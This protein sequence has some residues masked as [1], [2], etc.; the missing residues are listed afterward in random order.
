MADKDKRKNDKAVCG[1]PCSV[2]P[3]PVTCSLADGHDGLHLAE[4]ADDRLLQWGEAGH[5]FWQPVDGDGAER[6]KFSVT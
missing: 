6:T 4:I 2:L 3:D 1:E 5:V